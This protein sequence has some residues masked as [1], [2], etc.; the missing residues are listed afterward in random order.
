MAKFIKVR[1]VSLLHPLIHS[2][3]YQITVICLRLVCILC[4][5]RV[6]NATFVLLGSRIPSPTLRSPLGHVR[7]E[8]AKA[9]GILFCVQKD[10]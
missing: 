3:T 2:L 6:I 8:R 10:I 9:G 5:F 7:L 1:H 4:I